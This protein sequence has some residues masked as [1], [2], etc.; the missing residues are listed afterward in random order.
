M[1][2]ISVVIPTI[3]ES[4]LKNTIEKLLCGSLIPDEI[5][6]VIPKNFYHK[7]NNIN[8]HKCVKI[9][10]HEH[11]SQVSQRI[12]GFKNAINEL[13]LQ[14][15]ADIILDKHCLNELVLALNNK[16][17][18]CVSPKYSTDLNYNV[19][20][21]KIFFLN[22]FIKR[23]RSMKFWD[24]WFHRHYEEYDNKLLITK[25]LPGGCI[26]HRKKNLIL[27]NY[28]EYKGKAFDEDLIHSFKLNN[29]G[30][31]LCVAKK[32]LARSLNYKQYDHINYEDLFNY[33]FRVYK[34][35]K[36]IA[37]ES[38]GSVIFYHIWFLQWFFLEVIR[39]FKS[40]FF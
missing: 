36:N 12:F 37:K 34:I 32:A 8:F 40:K 25:W 16:K 3:G 35:K 21:F 18:I 2:K 24:T 22:Y 7:I 4:F 38:R 6:V 5:I 23:E 1:N 9:L 20:F 26:L 29:N 30:I 31:R 39:Y 10:V 33:I 28:Y 17:L 15:D 14:L 11:A 13:I 27:E 19:S